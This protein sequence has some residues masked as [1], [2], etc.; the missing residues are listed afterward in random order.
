MLDGEEKSRLLIIGVEKNG[1]KRSRLENEETSEGDGGDTLEI[2][3]KSNEGENG[4]NKSVLCR[5][6]GL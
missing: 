1:R 4:E 2:V 5:L 3:N 6:G